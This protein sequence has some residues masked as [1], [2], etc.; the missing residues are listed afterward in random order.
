MTKPVNLYMWLFGFFA[1]MPI[2]RIF[3][4]TLYTI[5]L[6]AFVPLLFIY[7]VT[8]TIK[9]KPANIEKSYV[10]I[11]LLSIVSSVISLFRMPQKWNESWMTSILQFV[12]VFLFYIFFSVTEQI[13]WLKSYVHGVYAA[14]LFQMG[15]GYLQ[16]LTHSFEINLNDMVFKE[17]LGITDIVE[18]TQ[19]SAKSIK[20]SGICWNAGN[21]APLL[22]FGYIY[23]NNIIIK[24]L[25]FVLSIVSGS[26]TAVLGIVFCVCFQIGYK[27]IKE[28]KV[29]KIGLILF[30]GGIIMGLLI[31]RTVGKSIWDRIVARGLEALLSSIEFAQEASGRVHARYILSVPEVTRKNSLINNLF[32]YGMGC[33]GYVFSAF[34]GQYENAGQWVVECDFVNYLWNF[35]YLGFIAYYYWYIKNIINAYAIDFKYLLLFATLLFQGIFYNVTFNWCNLL[36]V[37]IFLLAHKNENIFD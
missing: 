11:F 19:S 6:M 7:L 37:S 5:F 23:S 8:R 33:S 27:I 26:R 12:V 31:I 16:L 3:S 32:G 10:L 25:F 17:W 28:K 15:W 30:F 36:I 18:F 24:A 20:V 2:L 22:I 21:L 9:I 29:S 13:S 4:I 1:T 14:S 34:Y 35:G